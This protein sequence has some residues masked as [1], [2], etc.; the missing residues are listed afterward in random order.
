VVD[1]HAIRLRELR[2]EEWAD[3]ALA[4]VAFG[5]ALAAS[6]ALSEL[7]VPLLVA[8]IGAVVLALRAFWRRWEL[9]DRLLLERDAYAIPEVRAR[10]EGIASMRNRHALASSIRSLL[11]ETTF[12]PS[13]RAAA[14]A[15]EL[16]ALAS[17]LDDAELELTPRC[18]VLCQ[19]LLTEG[20]E[21]PLLNP[22]WPLEDAIARVRQIRGGFASHLV[23]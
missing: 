3:T 11:H 6:Q 9:L 18:A 15:G 14:L 2:G 13:A 19:H 22:A 1:E 10:A 20:G 21:S 5:L 4:L 17:E 8:F 12:T 16:E 7:V 23:A